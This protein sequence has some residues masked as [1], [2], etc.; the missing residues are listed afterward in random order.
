MKNVEYVYTFGMDRETLERRLEQT[1][2]GVLSLAKE[3]DAYAVP[4]AYHYDGDS[5]FLR[6]AFEG[7]STK[8]EYLEA[9]SE[10]CLCLYGIESDDENWSV[11]VQGTL[12]QLTGTERDRFDALTVN[13]TFERLH[14]FDQAI[15]AIDIEV[16]ELLADSITGRTT[17]S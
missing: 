4:I 16:Y 12:R 5:V 3:S 15:E 9:T 13:E 17:E 14:V 2:V 7:D 8:R 1:G 10:A 6:F 11:L